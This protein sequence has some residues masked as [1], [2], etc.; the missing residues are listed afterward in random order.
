MKETVETSLS[1]LTQLYADEVVQMEHCAYVGD[2]QGE[3]R[4]KETA[5]RIQ[6]AIDYVERSDGTSL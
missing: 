3:L 2:H 5:E 6:W 4:H 1:R